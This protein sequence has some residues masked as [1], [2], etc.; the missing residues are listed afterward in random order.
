MIK[1][2]SDEICSYVGDVL[3]LE[4]IGEGID[5]N[6]SVNWSSTGD[7]AAIRSF[8]GNGKYSFPNGVLV[9]LVAPG[10]AVIK[11]EYLGVEYVTKVT[12]RE[13]RGLDEE[14]EL[15]YYLG[16]LHDHT[17]QIHNRE[18]FAKHLT[19]DIA[20]YVNYIK[21]ENLIDFGVISDHASVTNDDDFYRGFK[22]AETCESPIIF[23]GAE[24]EISH[25]E[26]DRLGILHRHS[27]EI[28]TFMSA[29]YASVKT[30]EEFENEL[31]HS[32]APVA[33]FAHPH[34]VGFSTNGIWNF[35]F[36]KH[37][38]PTMKKIIRG[39]EMGNGEDRK[40]NLLHEYAYSAALDAGFKVSATC[41]SDSHGP[42]WGYHVMPGKTIILAREKSRE[43]FHEALLANRFYASESGNV[44]LKYSVNDKT[45]P[46]Q[47]ELTDS[48]RFHIELDSF[49]DDESTRPV[50]CQ[51]ISDYGRTIECADVTGDTIDLTVTSD[52]ARYFYLRLIDREG[53]KTW[54][55]P[56]WCQRAFDQYEE[57][58]LK[59]LDMTNFKATS[60][61]R[62]ASAVIDGDPFHSWHSGE[63]SPRVVIDMGD[64][65]EISGFGYY[66]HIVL[67][68][69]D[70]GPEWTT[71]VET[72]GLVSR[73]KLYTS[74]NGEHYSLIA[75]ITCQTLGCENV[76]SFPT[77]KARY[78]I[79][80]VISNIGI[81]S[82]LRAY[83][84]S[85]TVIGNITLFKNS[86]E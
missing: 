21:E 80:E 75:D 2:S 43:A 51:I 22:L 82:H 44:K 57:K 32:H 26:T 35:D 56:V 42:I 47:L 36:M 4:L 6:S 67:R 41:S 64:T 7:A 14:D 63:V 60:S 34:V 50:I 15:N 77:H 69:K 65:Q 66:P 40:E 48:Y 9:S 30:W 85:E 29:G 81:D 74:E 1:L 10:E 38:T 59:A 16:D 25:T 18:E 37:N 86:D 33:I 49:N 71:S 83:Q 79:M 20:D 84:R 3:P 62:D 23:A 17:S 52:S 70:K 54:S 76:V 53:R 11:A 27:G 8:K 45:A 39:V 68:S 24:S 58:R 46:A 72:R 31:T 55:M 61:G 28:V 78:V 12:A 19:E 13:M 73:Y 5:K